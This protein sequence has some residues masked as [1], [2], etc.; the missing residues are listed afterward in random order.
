M[1][2]LGQL[3]LTIVASDIPA[4]IL[5]LRT[6]FSLSGLDVLQNRHESAVL[7][8]F[9]TYFCGFWDRFGLNHELRR[10]LSVSCVP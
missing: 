1:N 4:T 6:K 7:L 3:I 10:Q 5:F 9:K 2:R 8:D